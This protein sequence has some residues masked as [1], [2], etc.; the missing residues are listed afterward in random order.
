V[1]SEIEES[2][3]S[4]ARIKEF[5]KNDVDKTI[6]S[7]IFLTA[8]GEVS[9]LNPLGKSAWKSA[10]DYLNEKGLTDKLEITEKSLYNVSVP[11]GTWK[12]GRMEA[13]YQLKGALWK[14]ITFGLASGCLIIIEEQRKAYHKYMMN[15]LFPEEKQKKKV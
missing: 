13:Y 14:S 8:N 2:Q 3:Y 12:R 7:L 5:L 11:W 15:H 4:Q 10:I 6:D 1:A 9:L